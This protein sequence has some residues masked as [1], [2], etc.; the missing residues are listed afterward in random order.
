MTEVPVP[1]PLPPADDADDAIIAH[2]SGIPAAML[3][4]LPA[5]FQQQVLALVLERMER[6]LH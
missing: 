1:L 3:E 6:R 4:H 5:E 2:W